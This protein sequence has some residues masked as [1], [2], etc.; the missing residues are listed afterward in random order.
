[1]ARTPG[2]NLEFSAKDSTGAAFSKL[3]DNL[4]KSSLGAAALG[5]KL[6]TSKDKGLQKSFSTTTATVGML[7]RSLAPLVAV[8]GV[9][10]LAKA[11]ISTNQSFQSLEASLITFL[12]SAKTA[13]NVFNELKDITSKTP[14][15]I[16]DV[17]QAYINLVSVGIKPT[18]EEFKAFGDVAGGTGKTF[19]QFT[20]AIR[21]ATTG[22]M[23]SLKQFGITA[24]QTATTVAFTFDD[25]TVSADKNAGSIAAALGKI[26]K[27][28][29]AGGMELQAKTLTGA[30]ANVKDELAIF[31][32]KIGEAGLNDAINKVARSLAAWI[33][34][35]NHLTIAIGR[36][37]VNAIELGSLSMRWLAHHGNEVAFVLGGIV[38]A[39]VLTNLYKLTV[40]VWAAVKSFVALEILVKT[41]AM[42]LNIGGRIV[43][44]LKVTTGLI[45]KQT[46][47]TGE[48]NREMKG[49]MDVLTDFAQTHLKKATKEMKEFLG[50]NDDVVEQVPEAGNALDLVA[51]SAKHLKKPILQ[52]RI[53]LGNVMEEMENL[54]RPQ[55]K[56]IE[57]YQKAAK[58][59]KAFASEIDID[60]AEFDKNLDF[61]GG[62][63]FNA[64]VELQKFNNIW[65]QNK[66][67]SA[68]A[69]VELNKHT[70]SLE[71]YEANMK[72]LNT[73]QFDLAS[74]WTAAKLG[75][76]DYFNE[77]GNLFINL[78]TT[79]KT[80]LEGLST[81]LQNFFLSGKMDF[82][83]FIKAIK[84]GL[85]SLAAEA[86]VTTGVKFLGTL[87]PDLASLLN[88]KDGGH[89]KK[90][91]DGGFVSGPGGPTTDSVLARLSDGE[92]VI[93]AGAV[94][95]IGIPALDRLNSSGKGQQ[96][97]TMPGTAGATSGFFLGGIF[98]WVK[99]AV[100]KVIDVITDTVKF[101]SKAVQNTVK[102]IM[103][104]ELSTIIPLLASFIVPGVGSAV[105]GAFT[106]SFAAGA[107]GTLV[108][109][110]GT[111]ISTSFAK[112]ILGT[113]GSLS[114]IA[115][116]VGITLAK[117][118]LT[119]GLSDALLVNFLGIGHS[120][121]SS[122]A[123]YDKAMA[124]NVGT[125]IKNSGHLFATGPLSSAQGGGTFKKGDA[126]RVGEAGAELF[127][128]QS[129]GSVAPIKSGKLIE[130]I[131]EVR[132]EMSAVR[133]RLDRAIAAGQL[134]GA[135]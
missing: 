48:L 49:I 19:S 64:G 11:I 74:V 18:V 30:F 25:M 110:I 36:F 88:F 126:V 1:M 68:A 53:G 62:S 10:G 118:V 32:N 44:G 117:G 43:Q 66:I 134:A 100:D 124:D 114:A 81:T 15:E 107:T 28:K 104:G 127:I 58:E 78:R 94:R 105:A 41:V 40:A 23:E 27:V 121:A 84:A 128:P 111:A 8:L 39:K 135:H 102:G 76:S 2:L 6:G 55:E 83:S 73:G 67:D 133:R 75:M 14:F 70:A 112:G 91:A 72:L 101:V 122:W 82:G 113:A 7:T 106:S 13:K 85:L 56:L 65:K 93:N 79:A 47:E 37:L 80:A 50:V 26:A 51:E 77:S 29:F 54:K 21:S 116:S 45:Q 96:M 125:L 92:Y 9:A 97:P 4:N 86:A 60:Y 98:D 89:V 87:M 38:T 3:Q 120:M 109:N 123:T 131:Y 46:E 119:Q 59:A 17:T 103:S 31:A 12:G 115:Q 20:Y 35:N 24:K 95:K 69:R 33:K 90:Y 71:L 42:F 34:E 5:A 16:A 57:N 52:V 63:I 108:G 22:E 129:N 130:A 61:L 99:D 132:D